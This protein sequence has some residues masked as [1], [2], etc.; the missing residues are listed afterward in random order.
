MSVVRSNFYR[1]FRLSRDSERKHIC[2]TLRLNKPQVQIVRFSTCDWCK[3][4]PTKTR[5]TLAV[6][7]RK[8]LVKVDGLGFGE[9]LGEKG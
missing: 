1:R 2:T 9:K 3:D 7:L 6:D 4:P 8:L 5:F